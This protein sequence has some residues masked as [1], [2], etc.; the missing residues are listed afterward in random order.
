MFRLLVSH[1]AGISY[2]LYSENESITPLL[3][4]GKKF[5]NEMLRWTIEDDKGKIVEVSKIHK[6]IIGF[7]R[8]AR[9]E[10]IE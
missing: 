6:E 5:D 4:Q 3:E 1:D 8:R 9:R 2:G 7:M 10:A